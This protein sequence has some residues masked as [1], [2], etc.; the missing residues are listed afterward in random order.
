[1]HKYSRRGGGGLYIVCVAYTGV[2]ISQFGIRRIIVAFQRFFNDNFVPKKLRFSSENVYS[3]LYPRICLV[4]ADRESNYQRKLIQLQYILYIARIH[5]GYIYMCT[6]WCIY[7]CNRVVIYY[8][9]SLS[10]IYTVYVVTEGYLY[11]ICCHWGVFIQY[12]LSLSSIYTVYVV[13][14]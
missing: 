3:C 10:S 13:T 2:Y 12:M 9:L 14:E 1:M 4:S 7:M 8:M 6:M 5:W 11:S